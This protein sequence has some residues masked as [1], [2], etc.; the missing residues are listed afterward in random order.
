MKNKHTERKDVKMQNVPGQNIVSVQY[1]T[2]VEIDIAHL[3]ARIKHLESALAQMRDNHERLG[4]DILT[5][6]KEKALFEQL[7]AQI[8]PTDS[9]N[10]APPDGSPA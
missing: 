8:E 1:E 6:E 2:N 10:P 7:L 3:P 9:T 5:V 4:R